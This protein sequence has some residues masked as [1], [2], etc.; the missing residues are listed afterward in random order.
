M[1]DIKNNN[2]L[3]ND[4]KRN[5]S[6]NDFPSKNNNSKNMPISLQNYYNG[7]PK[8]N[9]KN[10]INIKNKGNN[11]NSN[12]RS[13]IRLCNYYSHNIEIDIPLGLKSK[14]P[15][16]SIRA[17][18]IEDIGFARG[19]K[20]SEKESFHKSTI[21]NENK[22]GLNIVNNN[23]NTFIFENSYINRNKTIYNTISQNK[24]LSINHLLKNKKISDNQYIEEGKSKNIKLNLS[25]I[26]RD[27]INEYLDNEF[28]D[29]NTLES[30]LIEIKDYIINNEKNN[31]KFIKKRN[32]PKNKNNSI[33]NN[34]IH[35]GKKI[36]NNLK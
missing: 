25:L 22:L 32:I 23:N 20:N 33:Q 5:N 30:L 15:V 27:S 16:K 6:E 34:Y 4:H 11:N 2:I 8:R 24:D 10:A 19:R 12:T 28:I 1:G 14:S 18:G 9:K 3:I 36:N 21:N 13:I 35:N 7:S 29:L 26:K 17:K 31:N